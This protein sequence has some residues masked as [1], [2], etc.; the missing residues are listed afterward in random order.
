MHTDPDV[1]ALLALGEREAATTKDLDHIAH[2][3]NCGR[4]VA[5]LGQ[6]THVGRTISDHFTLESPSPQVWDRIRAQLGFRDDFSSGLVPPLADASPPIVPVLS[7]AD[8]ATARPVVD[9][10]AGSRRERAAAPPRR[11][12]RV[13]SLALAAVLALLAGIG[14]TLAWQQLQPLTDTVVASTPLDAF[15]DWTGAVGQ[16]RLETDATGRQVLEVSMATPRPVDGIQQIW[17]INPEESSMLPLGWLTAPI[18]RFTLP[19]DLDIS[20]YPVVDISVE[21]PD[22]NIAHSGN[23]IVRGTLDI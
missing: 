7:S 21:P 8:A 12:R 3:E 2:C 16:A 9:R 19:A 5:Q 17:L 23:S 13:V 18:E 20:R 15:P 4:E 6:L 11:K 14:G 10:T 1:L 22:G